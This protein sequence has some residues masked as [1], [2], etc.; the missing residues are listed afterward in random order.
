MYWLSLGC[1][2]RLRRYPKATAEDICAFL[3]LFFRSHQVAIKI[4][5]ESEG[6]IDTLK[7]V[8]QYD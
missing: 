5:K 3:L 7:C 4:D 1:R 2:Y 6:D 8:H